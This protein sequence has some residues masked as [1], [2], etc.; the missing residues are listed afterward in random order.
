MSVTLWEVKFR[1][2][3]YTFSYTDKAKTT[4][5]VIKNGRFLPKSERIFHSSIRDI[6][7]NKFIPQSNTTKKVMNGISKGINLIKTPG[8]KPFAAGMGILVILAYLIGRNKSKHK[9]EKTK[10][11]KT[12]AKTEEPKAQQTEQSQE[13]KSAITEKNETENTTKPT[14]VIPKTEYIEPNNNTSDTIMYGIK[15]TGVEIYK[16]DYIG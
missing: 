11:I 10:E 14:P 6:N 7:T 8:F 12:I 5:K 3:V 16:I 15:N 2:K 13:K 4:S 1:N 9:V